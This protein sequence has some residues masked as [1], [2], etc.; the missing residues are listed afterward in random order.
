MHS[1]AHQLGYICTCVVMGHPQ[2]AP[3]GVCT[4]FYSDDDR[5]THHQHSWTLLP[6]SVPISYPFKP[7]TLGNSRETV[8]ESKRQN[9]PRINKPLLQDVSTVPKQKTPPVDTNTDV[10]KFGFPTHSTTVSP[11]NNTMVVPLNSQWTDFDSPETL[12]T[13]YSNC[14]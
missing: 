8:E 5:L 7:P 6:L 4:L 11:S 13:P 10:N 12:L 2:T 1:P 9:Q 3:T 14:M